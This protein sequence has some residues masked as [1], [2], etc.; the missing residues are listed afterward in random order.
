MV[1]SRHSEGKLSVDSLITVDDRSV[2]PRR[3]INLMTSNPFA[4]IGSALIWALIALLTVT[5]SLIAIVCG[6]VLVPIDPQ[7][8]V[9][10][11]VNTLWGESIFFFNPLWRCRVTGRRRLDHRRTYIYIANHQSMLDIMALFSV[12]RQFKWVSKES[13][14]RIPFLGWAMR[15]AG[16]ISLL[17]GDRASIRVTT[18]QARA[19][20]NNGMSVVFFPEG[21]R[22]ATGELLPFKNGAFRLAAEL[23]IPVVPVAII[24]TRD[25]LVKGSWLFLGRR[26]V[27][28]K[29]LPPIDVARYRSARIDGLRDEAFHAIARALKS[30]TR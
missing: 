13:L 17:R 12:R 27:R 11:W 18:D 16:Y 25:L 29:V 1:H 20:L 22:S 7:R 19:Y 24:G 6:V 28:V 23:G 30:K 26:T 10:H 9:A 5:F 14:F 2:E 4:V 15:A 8:R 21:T 3:R